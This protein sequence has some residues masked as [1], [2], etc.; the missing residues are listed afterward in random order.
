MTDPRPLVENSASPKE[1]REARKR[2]RF[3]KRAKSDAWGALID[4]EHG[5]F[6]LWEILNFAG[7]YRGGFTAERAHFN[8][9]Q[10]NV[11]LYVIAQMEAARPNALERLRLAHEKRQ[12]NG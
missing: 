10:R 3:S 5:A 1:V 9:G 12:T 4:S 7:V 8:E 2:A 6:V 11:G